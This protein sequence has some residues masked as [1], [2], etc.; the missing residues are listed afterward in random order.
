M[1][2][3]FCNKCEQAK[4]LSAFGKRTNA[5]DGLQNWCRE[6]LNKANKDKAMSRGKTG[7]TV[8]RTFKTCS[9]CDDTKPISQFYKKNKYSAD[10]YGNLCKPCWSVRI[11][12]YQKKYLAKSR[13]TYNG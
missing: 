7:P 12:G 5:K 4:E 3:K 9:R 2:D 13:G 8:I 10:G 1:N 11:K 6:C